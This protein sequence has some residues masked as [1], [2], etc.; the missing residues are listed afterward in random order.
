[1]KEPSEASAP[2]PPQIPGYELIGP[3]GAG[4]TA[5]VWKARQVS[6]DRP[7][8]IKVLSPGLLQDDASRSAFLTEARAAAKISHPSVVGILDFGETSDGTP[9]YVMEYVEGV[10]LA[11]GSHSTNRWPPSRRSSSAAS[12]PTRSTPSGASTR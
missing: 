10:S 5:V 4:G 9:Y 2:T 6:L 7:V 11:Y 3:I 8:A 1:M 12:S